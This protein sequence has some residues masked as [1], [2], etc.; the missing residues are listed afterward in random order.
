M[1]FM[2]DLALHYGQQYIPLK[3]VAQRQGISEKYLEQ[4]VPALNRAG[5]VQSIRGS[6]G[7]YRLARPPEAYSVGMIIRLMEGQ[8]APAPCA[9]QHDHNE[10]PMADQCVTAGVW[11]KIREAVDD[12]VDHITLENLVTEYYTKIGE[13]QSK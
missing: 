12:V 2:V 13:K 10:C 11:E 6:Q 8:L 5:F 9:S 3:E 4:I 7:G 1:R